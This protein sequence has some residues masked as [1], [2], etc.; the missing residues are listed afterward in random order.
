MRSYTGPNNLPASQEPGDR[1]SECDGDRNP[2]REER[3]VAEQSQGEGSTTGCGQLRRAI[4]LLRRRHVGD[5]FAVVLLVVVN[6][7]IDCSNAHLLKEGFDVDVVFD[8][9]VEA[10]DGCR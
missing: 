4:L 7:T 5:Q 2:N 3:L 6:S 10:S 1:G 8:G 9:D